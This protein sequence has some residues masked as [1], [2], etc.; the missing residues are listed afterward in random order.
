MNLKLI[1]RYVLIFFSSVF[2]IL[3]IFQL[4]SQGRF[5]LHFWYTPQQPLLLIF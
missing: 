5:F 2:L 4:N 1:L 3:L